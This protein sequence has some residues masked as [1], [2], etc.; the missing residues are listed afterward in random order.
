VSPAQ[1]FQFTESPENKKAALEMRNRLG[2]VKKENLL[3]V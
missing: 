3:K 2:E 1:R